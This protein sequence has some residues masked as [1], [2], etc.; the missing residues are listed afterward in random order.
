[1]RDGPG[2]ISCATHFCCA[3]GAARSRL[4][5]LPEASADCGDSVPPT[6][7]AVLPIITPLALASGCRQ[8]RK[9]LYFYFFHFYTLPGMMPHDV[10]RHRCRRCRPSHLSSERNAVTQWHR[11]FAGFFPLSS[12]IVERKHF[13]VP[14][15]CRA[16]P[17][18]PAIGKFG[19]AGHQQHIVAHP[20]Q[21]LRQIQ[22]DRVRMESGSNPGMMRSSPALV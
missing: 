22:T 9:I 10:R 15:F 17:G 6:M 13:I 5:Q 4:Q 20:R 11:Q 12:G 14:D 8:G 19:A 18:R 2:N 7:Y 3:F 16:G 21:K 1:M